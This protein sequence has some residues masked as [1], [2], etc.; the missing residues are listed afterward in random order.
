MSSNHLMVAAI[1][2][3]TTYS[4]YAFSMRGDFKEQPLNINA[5]Q[6]WNAGTKQLLSL[7]TPTVLLLDKNKTF[8]SFGYD[9][10]NQY[11]ELMMDEEHEEYYYFH[12]FKMK[13][14]KNMVYLIKL[15]YFI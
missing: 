6:S 5:N 7:K 14:H 12:R 15:Q 8:L 10:E 4:G 11:T 13:L 1:D 2:F 3:G 9:A